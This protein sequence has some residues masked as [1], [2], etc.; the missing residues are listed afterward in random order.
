MALAH[1]QFTCK[2]MLRSLLEVLAFKVL[3]LN[4]SQSCHLVAHHSRSNFLQNSLFHHAGANLP[5]QPVLVRICHD[6]AIKE[7]L[8]SSNDVYKMYPHNT[9]Y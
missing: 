8:L 2:H 7:V 9:S 5:L 4:S 1:A 3:F 6:C